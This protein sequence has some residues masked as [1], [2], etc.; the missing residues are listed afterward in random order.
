M[1]PTFWCTKAYDGQ[2]AGLF[3]TEED[4]ELQE[5]IRRSLDDVGSWRAPVRPLPQLVIR[6]PMEDVR[7][8][9]GSLEIPSVGPTT[10]EE[11]QPLNGVEKI[12][13]V[14]CEEARL[15]RERAR[16]G[17]AVAGETVISPVP[18]RKAVLQAGLE[19]EGPYQ[20]YLKGK[21]ICEN[22]G[23]PGGR[24]IGNEHLGLVQK[25]TTLDSSL[26][27]EGLVPPWQEQSEEGKENCPPS[28]VGV[29]ITHRFG[30]EDAG[31]LDREIRRSSEEISNS[32]ARIHGSLT[33]PTRNFKEAGTIAERPAAPSEVWRQEP[34]D[35]AVHTSV[36]RSTTH[37]NIP[38]KETN[39]TH[40]SGM[41]PRIEDTDSTSKKMGM[42]ETQNDFDGS[43]D[44]Q[45]RGHNPDKNVEGLNVVPEHI[46]SNPKNLLVAED[47][48]KDAEEMGLAKE[49]HEMLN[50]E[51]KLLVEREALAR[52][53]AEL[54]AA[55]QEEQEELRAGIEKERE[56]L[57]QE[58][59]ELREVQKKNERNADSV[60]GE[61]FA[62]CQVLIA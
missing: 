62:E 5:A 31:P 41:A 14:D 40:L 25:G 30:D 26:L 52:E 22:D 45:L 28:G 4:A 38:F 11:L 34:V 55:L 48:L 13:D 49:R 7:E 54:Q 20:E 2:S 29:V 59:I 51:A 23:T 44:V 15:A 1:L 19:A 43:R 6:E 56:L 60:T 17:K 16:K 21:G 57:F 61:M 10:G 32:D 53:E 33:H 46:A 58:E 18:V 8:R 47:I 27:S 37:S 35:Q 24:E 50:Y 42:L 3:L 39:S 36:E 12:M 9:S